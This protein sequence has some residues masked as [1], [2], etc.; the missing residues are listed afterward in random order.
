MRVALGADFAEASAR[1]KKLALQE[2]A[3]DLLR[4][5]RDRGDVAAIDSAFAVA[6]A[7]AKARRAERDR[8]EARARGDD[9]THEWMLG[10]HRAGR[11][12]IRRVS[13]RNAAAFE[14]FLRRRGPFGVDMEG[15]G[16][17]AEGIAAVAPKLVQISAVDPDD[18]P[19]DDGGSRRSTTT[20]TTTTTTT[21]ILRRP[22]LMTM[23]DDDDN[24][25]ESWQLLAEFFR[26]ATRTKLVFGGND[27]ACMGQGAQCVRDVQR[28]SMGAAT[29]PWWSAEK[30]LPS[31]VDAAN[32]FV[33]RR[34]FK[35]KR[36][37]VSDWGAR[38]LD[39]EQVAYAAWDAWACLAVAE[40]LSDGT[41]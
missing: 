4:R 16:D 2:A 30:A 12:R 23:L 14:A 7:E 31:L 37:S 20:T 26:D 10:Q 13:R 35:D 22:D 24:P 40:A 41:S 6:R 8:L 25:P 5:L 39:V 27:E 11:H 1:S 15:T 29:A 28:W 17:G 18:H 9:L 36:L 32:R 38:R 3:D 33:E 34:W 21:W 19:N